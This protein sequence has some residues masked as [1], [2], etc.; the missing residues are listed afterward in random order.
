MHT[1][2]D[3]RRYG[4]A[5]DID[6]VVCNTAMKVFEEVNRVYPV[7]LNAELREKVE[8]KKL[9]TGMQLRLLYD[10]PGNVP[11]WQGLSEKMLMS[12]LLNSTE[13]IDSVSAIPEALIALKDYVEQG[14]K[15]EM[16]ITSRLHH[17]QEITEKWLKSHDFPSAKVVT[18]NMGEN[19][20][21]WKLQW[22]YHTQQPVFG[23]LDNSPDAFLDTE[24]LPL[25]KIWL[26]QTKWW[27]FLSPP[28]GKITEVYDWEQVIEC[29][30]SVGAAGT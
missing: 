18:R 7:R 8:D 1:P 14:G 4:W 30:K 6:D 12:E 22:L 19:T 20:P 5:V 15:I 27:K 23:L 28:P 17:L 29:F 9:S 13:F 10:Q 16:Y 25:E 21:S 11:E 26:N 3:S 24:D 2:Q